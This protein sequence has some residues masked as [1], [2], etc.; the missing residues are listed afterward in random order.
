MYIIADMLCVSSLI[1]LEGG[2]GGQIDHATKN[3]EK[4]PVFAQ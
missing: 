1:V 2:E 4:V 3:L